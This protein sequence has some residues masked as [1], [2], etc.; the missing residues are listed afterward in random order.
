MFRFCVRKN[1][2]TS[3]IAQMTCETTWNPQ[4]EVHVLV[5]KVSQMYNVENA[6]QTT[7]EPLCVR[8]NVL[9][10]QTVVRQTQDM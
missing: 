8:R 5:N 3:I 1:P 10:S 2:E 9:G 4:H 6:A 7:L